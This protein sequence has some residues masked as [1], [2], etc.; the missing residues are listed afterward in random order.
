MSKLEIVSDDKN[1]YIY[2][3]GT[4]G[5]CLGYS[6]D[7]MEKYIN[8]KGYK[9]TSKH[10]IQTVDTWTVGFDLSDKEKLNKK[11]IRTNKQ[12]NEI[13]PVIKNNENRNYC[14]R[15]LPK[16]LSNQFH[17][18]YVNARKT[19]HL[20]VTQDCIGCKLCEKQCPIKVIEIQNKKPVWIKT[21]CL[22]CLRCLHCC[23]TFAIQYDDKT[24]K[25][26]QYI[27]PYIDNLN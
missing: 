7:Q 20:H 9:V 6:V 18:T 3:I 2:I 17:K 15:K 10:S 4:Y 11:L 16:F 19:K 14:K 21:E 8:M 12:I 24:R 22:M 5:L 27:N 23:P 26:G 1:P 25:H 13:I